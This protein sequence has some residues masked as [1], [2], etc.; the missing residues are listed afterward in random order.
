MSLV[1]QNI[2][3]PPPSPPG[4][5]V[6]A[7]DAG[8]THSPGGEGCGGL[9]FRKTRDIRLPSQSNYLSTVSS[10]EYSCAHGA[11]INFGHLAPYLTYELRVSNIAIHAVSWSRVLHTCLVICILCNICALCTAACTECPPVFTRRAN[12]FNL[13]KQ[14]RDGGGWNRDI[15]YR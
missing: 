3:P 6:P 14:Y 11:Q 12:F 7:F 9:I 4:E 8:G 10:N 15:Q 13:Q 1:F 2:D 5:C